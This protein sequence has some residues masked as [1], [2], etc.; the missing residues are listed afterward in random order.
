MNYQRAYEKAKELIEWFN[1]HSIEIRFERKKER[2]RYNKLHSELS[3]I[4]QEGEKHDSLTCDTCG[5]NPS[6]IV[7][8]PKGRFCMEHAKYV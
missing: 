7:Q 1:I 8:T 3:A 2:E 6:I 5:C 4:E